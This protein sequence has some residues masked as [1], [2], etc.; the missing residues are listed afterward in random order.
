MQNTVSD[1]VNGRRYLTSRL[2]E[3]M[4]RELEGLNNLGL[5]GVKDLLRN[6]LRS[7]PQGGDSDPTTV[8]GFERISTDPGWGDALV[9]YFSR[10]VNLIIGFDHE[11]PSNFY[12]DEDYDSQAALY[13]GIPEHARTLFFNAPETYQQLSIV[14]PKGSVLLASFVLIYEDGKWKPSKG[15]LDFCKNNGVKLRDTGFFLLDCETFGW[16]EEKLGR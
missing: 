15:T 9:G 2:E 1:I 8:N 12:S 11:A 4:S 3:R 7:R 5:E 10:D 14:T 16:E 6:T 13:D